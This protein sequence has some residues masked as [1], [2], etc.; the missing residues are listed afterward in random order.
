M[1]TWAECEED[2]V[3]DDFKVL[4][5][6]MTVFLIST[7]KYSYVLLYF[8]ALAFFSGNT[9]VLYTHIHKTTTKFYTANP[10]N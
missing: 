1:A 8:S 10:D 5:K 6:V 2:V 3:E 7:T 4:Y 9:I